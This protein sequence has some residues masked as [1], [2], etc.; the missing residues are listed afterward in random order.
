L[1]YAYLDNADQSKYGSILTGLNTQQTL[2]N[3][4]YPKTITYAN[5]MLSNHRLD[6]ATSGNKIT[7]KIKMKTGNKSWNLRRLTFPLHNYKGNVIAAE[8]QDTD[9]RNADSRINQNRN[10][11]YTKFHNHILK[12]ANNQQQKP[13]HKLL[14]Q[15]QQ[16]INKPL[17]NR[18]ILVG[19]EC[20]TSFTKLKTQRTGF[21]WIMN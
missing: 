20:I 10:R 15:H 9:H 6:N 8:N 4:Q 2:G 18:A 3:E 11:Q 19:Q 12:Q 7:I 5:S 21:Y 1:A 14:Q 13:N 17:S 16:T